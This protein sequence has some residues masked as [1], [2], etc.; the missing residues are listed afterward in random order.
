M[1]T[2]ILLAVLL[3]AVVVF[4]VLPK[5]PWWVRL[6]GIATEVLILVLCA[7][8]AIRGYEV[9]PDG[10]YVNRLF[11]K[12]RIELSGLRSAALDP[13]AVRGAV[14]IWGTDGLFGIYGLFQNKALGRFRVF[15]TDRARAV[16][17]RFER[18]TVVVTPDHPEEF[19]RQV[20]LKAGLG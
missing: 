2:V 16:V 18:R 13:D 19:V 5:M 3:G 9:T 4:V 11:W 14:K 12:T 20:R 10:L 8:W 1:A 15:A 6:V 17:L 7:L